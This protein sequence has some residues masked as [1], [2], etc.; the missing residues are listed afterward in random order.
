MLW[1]IDP[2]G[3]L[4]IYDQIVRQVKFAVA[5][6]HLAPG[7]R[8]PSVRELARELTV[9]PNTIARAYQQ[10]QAEG[11][12]Q[13]V[14]GLGLEI[15]SAAVAKC[16]QERQ[17]LVR[18]R[19]TACLEEALRSGLAPDDLRHTIDTVLLELTPAFS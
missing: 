9:N 18:Q 14:R 6:G 2:A 5:R 16:Q 7:N 13:T 10:L 15:T 8:L 19:L 12:A 4:A 1:H 3:E 17:Q 11:L